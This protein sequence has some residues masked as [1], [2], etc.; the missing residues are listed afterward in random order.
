[1]KVIGRDGLD[2]KPSIIKG[3]HNLISC[4]TEFSR[5][6]VVKG[7]LRLTQRALF[8][9]QKVLKMISSYV[10]GQK[11]CWINLFSV[12]RTRCSN[13]YCIAGFTR[14]IAVVRDPPQSHFRYGQIM[15][16]GNLAD[17]LDGSKVGVIPIPAGFVKHKLPVQE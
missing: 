9:I 14:Q 8:K 12:F 1:M 10:F 16:F 6:K 7:V 17:R 15:C 11:S 3:F 4:G 5:G 2:R 13:N